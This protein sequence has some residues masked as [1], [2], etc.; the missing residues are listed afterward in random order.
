MIHSKFGCSKKGSKSSKCKEHIE[1]S[2]GKGA[3][4]VSER[5]HRGKR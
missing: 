2:K 3:A 4:E 5:V 1:A